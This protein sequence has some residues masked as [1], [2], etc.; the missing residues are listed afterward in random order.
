MGDV[1]TGSGCGKSNPTWES[2]P[3]I[4]I[5]GKDL[6]KFNVIEDSTRSA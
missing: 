2:A 6:K 1:K 3:L 5:K 4:T